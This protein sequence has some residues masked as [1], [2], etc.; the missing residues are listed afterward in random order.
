VILKTRS[1]PKTPIGN[2]L[3]S[4]MYRSTQKI[5][6]MITRN[7]K[8]LMSLNTIRV[9][10]KCKGHSRRE[11]KAVIK[12]IEIIGINQYKCTI[13]K[14]G[15]HWKAQNYHQIPVVNLD[16]LKGDRQELLD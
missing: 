12:N 8:I 7:F 5:R 1:T 9:T 2:P 11:T 15:N 16:Q 10:L 4:I 13:N 14:L 3:A 6:L